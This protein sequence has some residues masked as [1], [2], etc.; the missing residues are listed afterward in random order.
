MELRLYQKNA[1]ELVRDAYRAGKR[2]P[3]LVAPTGSGKT[4]IFSYIASNAAAKGNNVLILAH[5]RELIRQAV[6]KLRDNGVQA[7]V[8]APSFDFNRM[9]GVQVASVQ[10]LVRRKHL[11]WVPDL[12]IVD[13]CHH[14]TSKTYTDILER[15][16]GARILG[17]TATPCRQDGRGLGDVFDALVSGPSMRELIALGHLSDYD[18]YIPPGGFDGDAH[19]KMGDFAQSEIDTAMSKPTIVGDAVAHYTRLCPN[20]PAVV[21]CTSVRHAEYVAEAFRG[22]GYRFVSVDGKTPAEIREERIQS[23]GDG[24]LHGITSCD[25]ISE[26]TDIPIVTAAILMRPTM[27][28]GLYLQQVG[29]VLRPAPNKDRA[30]ILDHA[31][32]V[33]RHGLPDEDR[34]W[35]LH[36]TPPKREK[37]KKDDIQIKV[38]ETCFSAN[39]STNKVC[40]QC[41]APFA[42]KARE[43]AVVEGDLVKVEAEMLNR[44]RLQRIENREAKSLQD[45]INIANKRGY[46]VGWAYVEAKRRGLM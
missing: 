39:K 15:F 22:A 27:S 2:A 25:I 36:R 24:R 11:P 45:L 3:L 44:K 1:V 26:G 33:Y 14:A 8:I 23:L 34:G 18:I 32:N 31:G 4:V 43:A 42:V 41:G 35:A 21:F 28:E 12:I 17:V 19:I 29:R 9:A 16:P 13:E 7:S 46:K 40:A 20:A 6:G 5:R 10:T 37:K 30:I 38:C